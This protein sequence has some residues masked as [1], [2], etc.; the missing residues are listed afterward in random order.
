MLGLGGLGGGGSC[1]SS[2]FE[3]C[4]VFSKEKYPLSTRVFRPQS[5]RS[6]FMEL[7]SKGQKSHHACFQVRVLFLTKNTL[8]PPRMGA[9]NES[10]DAWAPATCCATSCT[11]G[12]STLTTRHAHGDGGTVCRELVQPLGRACTVEKPKPPNQEMDGRGDHS[13]PISIPVLPRPASTTALQVQGDGHLAPGSGEQAESIPPPSG[14][15]K[16]MAAARGTC[17]RPWQE[18]SPAPIVPGRTMPWPRRLPGTH[19]GDQ[20]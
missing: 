9:G 20:M 4:L 18:E 19:W 15:I 2:S 14:Q 6:P 10:R 16:E 11:L 12:F 7:S 3:S 17:P 5:I 8:I 1:C 13:A